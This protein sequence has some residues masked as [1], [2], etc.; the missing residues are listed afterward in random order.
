M[1]G[2]KPST[3]H[4][5]AVPLPVALE[6]LDGR[7]LAGAVRAEQPEDLADRHLEVDSTHRLERAVGLAQAPDGDR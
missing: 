3:S 6:D 5:A 2:S 4:L 1:P 7:G